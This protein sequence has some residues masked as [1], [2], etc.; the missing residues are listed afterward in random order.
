MTYSESNTVVLDVRDIPPRVM[1]E[2]QEFLR[3]GMLQ[4]TLVRSTNGG[5][6]HFT[7]AFT[8]AA[9]KKIV[10]WLKSHEAQNVEREV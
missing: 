10:S 1:T 2:F 4:P 5:V 6:G 9:A 8:P 7:G 3:I